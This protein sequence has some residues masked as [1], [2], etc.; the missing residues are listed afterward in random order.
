MPHKMDLSQ[1]CLQSDKSIKF[2]TQREVACRFRATPST[3]INWRERGLLRYFQAPGSR[4]VLY[5]VE[6][7][8]EFESKYIKQKGGNPES[9]EVKGKKLETPSKPHREWRV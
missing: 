9:F 6:A 7:I 3:I 1:D 5:P 2:L 8:E 4:K